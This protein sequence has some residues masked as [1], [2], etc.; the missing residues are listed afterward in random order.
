[1]ELGNPL[2]KKCIAIRLLKY[3]FNNFT[4]IG[5]QNLNPNPGSKFTKQAGSESNAYGSKPPLLSKVQ[6]NSNPLQ[7]NGPKIYL[8]SANKYIIY[9]DASFSLFNKNIQL[10][11]FAPLN[12]KTFNKE[13]IVL[14]I[15]PASFMCRIWSAKCEFV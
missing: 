3:D 14:L 8:N 12:I 15:L 10:S 9:I 4:N 1:M 6:A 2:S 5:H 11:L 13:D 7:F